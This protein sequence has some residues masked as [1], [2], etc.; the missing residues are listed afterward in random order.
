[1]QAEF[2]AGRGTG[3]QIVNLM[4]ITK[5]AREFG[6]PLHVLHKLQEGIWC[7]VTQSTT[8]QHD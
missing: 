6:Q 5:K 7:G 4:L 8:D 2:R 3:D 1:M